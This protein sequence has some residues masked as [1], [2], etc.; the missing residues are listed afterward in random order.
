MQHLLNSEIVFL[1]FGLEEVFQSMPIMTKRE[2]ITPKPF[3]NNGML[4]QASS[5][6]GIKDSSK[7]LL[8]SFPTQNYQMGS[9]DPTFSDH[10]L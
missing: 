2:A 10:K 1:I 8:V 3:K 6:N 5:K 9:K 7:L 4:S